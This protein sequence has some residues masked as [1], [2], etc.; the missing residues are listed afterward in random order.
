MLKTFQPADLPAVFFTLKSRNGKVGP[1]PVSTTSE[2]TCPDACPLKGPGGCYAG[3]GPLA[4]LWKALSSTTAGATFQRGP[5]T[6]QSLTWKQFCKMVSELEND[7]LWRHNQAGDLPGRNNKI[8]RKA[9]SMLVRA[10]HGRRGFT[11]SHYPID[12]AEGANNRK[13]IAEANAA[14]FTINLSA[15]NLVEADELAAA[16]IGPVVVVLPGTVQGNVKIET[17]SGRRVVVCPATYRED[18]N[19][20]SCGLCQVR[21]R[22]VIVGFPAH[23]TGARKASATAGN[24]RPVLS[25][26]KGAPAQLTA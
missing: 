15:D 9:L 2:E 22:P 13:A 16:D 23:G 18:T 12:G 17:P 3:Y 8:N 7:A 14:G 21:D 5:N 1:M 19:C 25:W 4:M 10:N 26:S 11:Y 24:A 6:L 20:K